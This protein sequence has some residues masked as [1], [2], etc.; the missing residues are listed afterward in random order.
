MKKLLLLV[1]LGITFSLSAFSQCTP[2]TFPGPALTLPD[3]S[4]GLKPAVATLPYHE[5][6]HVRIPHDTIIPPLT[7]PVNIDSAGIVSI[8]GM[9]PGFNYVSNSPTNF[10]AGGTYGCAVIQ[11]L[12]TDADTGIYFAQ[13]LVQVVVAGNPLAFTYPYRM[14]VLSSA[15]VG[16]SHDEFTKFTVHQNVPNPFDDKTIIKFNTLRTSAFTFK[17]FDVVGNEVHSEDILA[18]KGVNQI[19]FSKEKLASGVY[20]YRLSDTEHSVVKRMVIR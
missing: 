6:I 15:H 9:P 2:I 16:F 1:V 20:F 12:A 5:V 4:Q 19:T 18:L 11:G 17:V 10:W 14:E 8:S 7:V 3:T 13:V